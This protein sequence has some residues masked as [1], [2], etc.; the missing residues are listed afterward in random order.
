MFA[1]FDNVDTTNADFVGRSS[2]ASGA[3]GD[4]EAGVTRRGAALDVTVRQRSPCVPQRDHAHRRVE[5]H[6]DSAAKERAVEYCVTASRPTSHTVGSVARDWINCNLDHTRIDE[7]HGDAAQQTYRDVTPLLTPAFTS[8]QSLQVAL[9]RSLS[10][11]VDGRYVSRSFLANT[12]DA[13]FV[14]PPA[15]LMDAAMTW[16]VRRVSVLAQL[17]NRS[18][19]SSSAA[20]TPTAPRLTTTSLRRAISL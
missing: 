16:S 2:R 18:T 15:W 12:G 1:G 7:Y 9:T 10:M 13:R 11:A 6:R 20:V 17:R 5:L 19:A 4:A 8:N 3:G 14:T